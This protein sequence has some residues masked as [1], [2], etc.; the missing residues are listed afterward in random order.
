MGF[1]RCISSWKRKRKI[2]CVSARHFIA[3]QTQMANSSGRL[4]PAR[5]PCCHTRTL[6]QSLEAAAVSS[7]CWAASLE[8]RA[9]LAIPTARPQQLRSSQWDR[10]WTNIPGP[11]NE[12]IN[13]AVVR[14]S[15]SPHTHPYLPTGQE[16][17]TDRVTPSKSFRITVSSL[18]GNLTELCWNI[19]HYEKC[20]AN[21]KQF[22]AVRG[23]PM[24]WALNCKSNDM[25]IFQVLVTLI[26]FW[27]SSESN[28]HH[29]NFHSY[30]KG[31]T[32]L[33]Q[34][35]FFFLCVTATLSKTW[36]PPHVFF[37]S[38]NEFCLGSQLLSFPSPLLLVLELNQ[39]PKISAY[40]CSVFRELHQ[41]PWIS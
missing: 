10:S 15:E 2:I 12:V 1:S 18:A 30:R 36:K 39:Y 23:L 13:T 20:S 24:K 33:N 35:F 5:S 21:L 29:C 17:T 32:N 34:I 27:N 6:V 4:S 28:K 25:H 22:A 11:G 3:R 37:W 14:P 7:S 19:A 16:M 8:T 9:G 41:V 38:K 26:L 40:F 31:K